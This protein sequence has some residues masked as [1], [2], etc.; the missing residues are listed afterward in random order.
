MS[1]FLGRYVCIPSLSS[2]FM[3]AFQ[4]RASPVAAADNLR[5]RRHSCCRHFA[6]DGNKRVCRESV[7]RTCRLIVENGCP[8][9]LRGTRRWRALECI[10]QEEAHQRLFDVQQPVE[11]L[12]AGGPATSG[13][14]QLRAAGAQLGLSIAS[15]R[16]APTRSPIFCIRR[17]VGSLGQSGGGARQGADVLEDYSAAAGGGA[18][19]LLQRGEGAVGPGRPAAMPAA[20]P[21]PISPMECRASMLSWSRGNLDV[22]R[23]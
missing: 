20:A 21:W 18:D 7:R 16:R 15:S 12:A 17:R 14:R 11:G 2:P 22:R 13:T 1:G 5:S 4:A 3:S 9:A 8:G 23:P 6:A 10:L 19:L